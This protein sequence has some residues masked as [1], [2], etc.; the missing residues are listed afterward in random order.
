MILQYYIIVKL[1]YLMIDNEGNILVWK[2]GK[3][4]NTPRYYGT[5]TTKSGILS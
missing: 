2:T 4:K 3:K 1:K 5:A